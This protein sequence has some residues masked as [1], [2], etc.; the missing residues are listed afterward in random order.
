[1]QRALN[2]YVPPQ[3]RESCSRLLQDGGA[4]YDNTDVNPKVLLDVLTG[5][6]GGS[7][8]VL[9]L[10]SHG[11]SHEA[12]QGEARD[13]LERE[14]PCDLC[15]KSHDPAERERQASVGIDGGFA[16]EHCSLRS[17]E[18]Y[19]HFPH[20]VPASALESL[21]PRFGLHPDAEEG[22]G[23]GGGGSYR[24]RIP[25]RHT[26]HEHFDS[27]LYW[28]H[29]H[30]A[31]RLM[32]A[33]HPRR[34]VVALHNY[35]GSYGMIKHM[36]A[37]R[38]E[39]YPELDGWPLYCATAAGE[40]EGAIPGL[41]PLFFEQLVLPGMVQHT[42]SLEDLFQSVV[43]LYK[44]QN[45]SLKEQAGKAALVAPCLVC[46]DFNASA[47]LLGLCSVCHKNYQAQT[48]GD[49]PDLAALRAESQAP[50]DTPAAEG[51]EWNQCALRALVGDEATRSLT[52]A[53][54]L[55]LARAA[56]SPA[57]AAG[58]PAGA[59]YGPGGA[60]MGHANL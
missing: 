10:Y 56:G 42:G 11:W 36:E 6:E 38:R 30:E 54:L 40:Y 16:H 25:I 60:P 57:G 37:G 49:R 35:C 41:F 45:P 3:V 26:P 17:R 52:V 39:A 34:P 53:N 28:Q 13:A 24:G 20:S 50:A 4:H 32:F 43:G 33:R 9:G 21:Y 18:W 59:P 7:G 58:S 27:L 22:E 29:L 55:Q 2:V 12:H 47:G 44:E 5:L 14:L 8:V 51:R 1:M 48:P 31:Y 23:E 15:G 19:C 46:R